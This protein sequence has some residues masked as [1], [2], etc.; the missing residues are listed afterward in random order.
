MGRFD[1]GPL[2]AAELCRAVDKLRREKRI[3]RKMLRAI[4]GAGHYDPGCDCEGCVARRQVMRW[5]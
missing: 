3:L 1:D 4:V 2:T 5:R